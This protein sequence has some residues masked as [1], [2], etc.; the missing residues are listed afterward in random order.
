VSRRFEGKTAFITGAARGQGRA[1]AVAFASEGANI[2]VSDICEDIATAGYELGSEADL[3]ETVRICEEQEART[4]SAKVDVRDFAAQEAF[5]QRTAAELGGIDIVVANA[6]IFTFSP[7]STM[8]IEKFDDTIDTNLK[9]VFY[10]CR[11]TLPLMTGKGWGRMILI[12]S[13]ASLVGNQN[14]AHYTAAKH[15]VLGLTK[16]LAIEV[17]AEGITV[18]CVCPTSVR[19]PMIENAGLYALVSPD[20]PTPEAA[21][22][23]L[24]S[25]NVI[26]DAWVEPEEVSALAI[27]LA[28]DEASHITGADMKIDMGLVTR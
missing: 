10:T 1:H 21:A 11:A 7:V 8:S 16:S 14:V 3:A 23:V 18:N 12:G 13:T 25:M 4:I 20:E 24:R 28:S 26:P 2:A 17:A 19:T 6:G 9:G 22:E 5:A 15:G 27:F